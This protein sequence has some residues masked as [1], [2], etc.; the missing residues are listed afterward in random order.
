MAKADLISI[1]C[2]RGIVSYHHYGI[3]I[4]DGT[5]VHLATTTDRKKMTVQRVSM[6]EFAKGAE[7]SVEA[8][9]DELPPDLVVERSLAAVG[10]VGYDLMIGNCEHFAR[11]MKTGKG[12]SHQVDMCVSSLVRAA[13][14][15][16][17][18]ASRKYVI[19][20]SLT[21]ISQSKVLV[22]AGSLVPT[23]V[24]ETARHG[25]YYA[26]RKLKMTHEEA[27][28]S[29]RSV[30]HA[31]CAIGGFIVGGPAGSAGALA[32]SIAADRFSDAIQ[33]KFFSKD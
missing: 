14:S 11:K 16:I 1:L 27:D 13:F 31:A 25:S 26:A 9:A 17:A 28:R 18:S 33:S 21:A 3:D 19:A 8:V 10:D 2:V 29:S 22:V 5:V 15:G 23:V 20:G 12:Q 30:S 32:I 6:E 7:V 4:G 24:G